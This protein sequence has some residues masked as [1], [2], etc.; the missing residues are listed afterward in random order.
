MKKRLLSAAQPTGLIHIG[1]YFGAIKQWADLQDEY[2]SFVGVVDLHALTVPYEAGVISRQTLDLTKVYLAAGIDPKRSTIFL[3][4]LVPQHT[5]LSWILSTMSYMGEL[6][7]MTQYKD[8]SDQHGNSNLGLFAYPVLMAADILLYNA[9][10]VPVG[11]DQKQHLELSR[12][13]AERFN[14]KFGR[15]FNLPEPK[16][17]EGIAG[18]LK[19]LDDPEKKMSK[20]AAS[21]ANYIAILDSA[22]TI[23][24]KIS[25][26]VTDNEALVKFD[27]ENKAGIS[28]L[29]TIY[30]LVSGKTFDSIEQEFNGQNYGAFKSAVAESL[31]SYLE[32]IQAKYNSISDQEARTI[33]EEGSAKTREVAEQMLSQVKAKIGLL[34]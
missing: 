27:P 4:S 18:R 8:K 20:S 31:I 15:T 14:N 21:A 29:M 19:G 7:R 32:P 10:L 26:A 28:N 3:Q 11:D 6:E 5:E 2:E 13:L 34:Q 24:A 1:N 16:I 12:N 33:L 25:K 17:L 9:D 30:S 22:D 23:R